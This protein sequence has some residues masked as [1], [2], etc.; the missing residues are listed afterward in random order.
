MEAQRL[1][2]IQQIGVQIAHT[3][4]DSFDKLLDAY[5]HVG[6]AMPGRL[7]YQASFQQHP[8][9]ATVLEEYYAAILSFH[10]SAMKV[11]SRSSMLKRILMFSFILGSFYCPCRS[12]S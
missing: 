11:F 3:Y 7:R 10:Q 1:K 6:K 9:Q 5:A 4:L 2:L 8:P 12:P